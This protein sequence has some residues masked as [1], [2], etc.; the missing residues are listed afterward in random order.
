MTRRPSEAPNDGSIAA[1]STVEISDN[2]ESKGTFT[3]TNGIWTT[4]P[5]SVAPGSHSF[6]AQAKYGTEPVS[7]A[8]TFN[9][10]TL[11]DQHKPYIQQAENNGSGMTLDLGTFSGD[12]TVKAIAWPGIALG[13]KVWL[14]CR[15]KKTNGDDHVITLY[16]AWP[17]GDPELT[18][19]LSRTLARAD[20]ELL[21]DNTGLTVEL[22]VQ[23]NGSTVED[24]AAVFP[25]RTYAI[26]TVEVV[27]PTLIDITDSKGTVV[28]G[29]T[30][31]TSVT[32]TG[33]GSKGQQIQLM[34]GDSAIGDVVDIPANT[35]TW[36]TTLTGL[37]AKAYSLKAKALYGSG[38]ESAVKGF[39]VASPITI[40]PT[41]MVLSTWTFLS[42]TGAVP[43]N[44][45]EGAYGYRQPTGGVPP[46]QY[47]SSAP[48]IAHVD[49]NTGKVTS[50]G[51]GAAIIYAVDKN[52]E[53]ASYPVAVSN[54]FVAFGTGINGT[55]KQCSA[56][57]SAQGGRIPTRD[58]WH[59]MRLDY[60][61]LPG[62]SP[63]W[64]W[65]S[66]A[67]GI[68]YVYG[69]LTETGEEKALES[70]LGRDRADGFGIRA[71]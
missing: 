23:F 9:V 31:E 64:T 3:A 1:D 69:I 8:R 59:R 29:T 43:P 52:G 36:D 48:N 65:S 6:T 38:Q 66:T 56:A 16:T 40:D 5:I 35:T 49:V 21:G 7:A 42:S 4:T 57:A 54:V 41:Q 39:T 62:V 47:S 63:N 24:G 58:E 71:K 25:L 2:G 11:T 14:S 32:V 33:T 10:I 45:Y 67:W 61:G 51:N 55:Y 46:Y 60:N 27:A 26:K 22:K 68:G 13:Q 19:G 28:D 44:P 30:T 34:D 53:H 37:D 20:L 15:G 17:V 18:V 70:V 50:F 12:A